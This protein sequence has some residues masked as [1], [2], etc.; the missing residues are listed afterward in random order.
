MTIEQ[1]CPRIVQE[2]WGSSDLRAWSALDHDGGAGISDART[3]AAALPSPRSVAGSR[4]RAPE[5][6]A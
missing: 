1:T 3:F 4:A 2:P 5:I 6:R